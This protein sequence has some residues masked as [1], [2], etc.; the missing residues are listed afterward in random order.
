MMEFLELFDALDQNRDGRLTRAELFHAALEFG[1]Q[2]PQAHLYAL[3]D[4]LA[5]RSPLSRDSFVAALEEAGHDP[6]GVYGEVLRRGPLKAGQ[7][8]GSLRSRE[9]SAESPTDEVLWDG[10]AAE[11]AAELLR[12][13]VSSERAGDYAEALQRSAVTNYSVVSSETA[14]LL[15]DPQ[16]SFTAG[17]WLWRLGPIGDMEAMPIRLAFDNSARLLRAVYGRVETMFSRCPFAPE[18]YGWDEALVPILDDGQAYFLKP[19][20]NL[21][22]PNSNGYGQWLDALVENGIRTLVIGGCTLNSCLRVSAVATRNAFPRENLQVVVDLS[23]CG[24]RTSNYLNTEQF[25]GI[26]PVEAAMR[27]MVKNGVIVAGQ[28]V[29]K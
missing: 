20:N 23:L 14:L 19:S 2:G 16:R 6:Q 4:F 21:L 18:S 1:W 24:A 11:G 26:S 27:E 5:L 9:K 10:S 3:L 8:Y 22:M 29:W 25:G 7:L 13:I 12:E 17:E 15:I 28:V